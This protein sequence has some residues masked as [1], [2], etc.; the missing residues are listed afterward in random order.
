MVRNMESKR[1]GRKVANQFVISANGCVYFQ[2]YET[3]IAKVDENGKVTLSTY[4]D[5]SNT[6]RKYLYQFLSEHGY[7]GM[8][9]NK[10]L[11]LIGS[12]E[13]NYVDCITM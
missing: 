1:T 7:C 10:V 11:G 13:F 9:G 5:C 4:W 2:S 12:K 3:L 6:T 8:N